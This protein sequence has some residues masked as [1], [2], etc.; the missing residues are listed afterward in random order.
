MSK[1]E[2]YY[3]RI[4]W[5]ANKSQLF[6]H[7]CVE[8]CNLEEQKAKYIKEYL[9]KGVL[10]VLVFWGDYDK[11]TILCID[12]LVSYYDQQ[13]Y[14]GDLAIIKADVAPCIEKKYI[15]P[16]NFTSNDLLRVISQNGQGVDKVDE[17]ENTD[18]LKRFAK[19]LYLKN[20]QEFIWMPGTK[21]VYSLWGI[22]L[23]IARKKGA[24]H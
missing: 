19:W 12:S 2:N 24:S 6:E 9:P 18:N 4:I 17:I 11:W 22:L 1:E 14:I 7:N 23:V 15:E 21:E 8:F 13:L 3:E 5:K 20:T 16:K 10:P